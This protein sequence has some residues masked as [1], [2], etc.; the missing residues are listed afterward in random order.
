MN[1]RKSLAFHPV[2]L[3]I[4]GINIVMDCTTRIAMNLDGVFKFF[5]SVNFNIQSVFTVQTY[6]SNTPYDYTSRNFAEFIKALPIWISYTLGIKD[7]QTLTFIWSGGLSLINW[8]LVLTTL[9]LVEK[10]FPPI[11]FYMLSIILTIYAVT[12]TSYLDSTLNFALFAAVSLFVLSRDLENKKSKLV[13]FLII[14]IF[15]TSTHEIFLPILVI[16]N[17]FLV[18]Q[19]LQSLNARQHLLLVY[20]T[21]RVVIS[22]SSLLLLLRHFLSNRDV[23]TTV[24]AALSPYFLNVESYKTHPRSILLM[25]ALTVLLIS[26]LFPARSSLNR[27]TYAILATFLIPLI[28]FLVIFDY[29]NQYSAPRQPFLEFEYRPDY[30]ILILVFFF[31]LLTGAHS[32]RH[33][34]LKFDRVG[35]RQIIH[36]SL[37]TILIGNSTTH[38]IGNLNWN[39][40]WVQNIQAQTNSTLTSNEKMFGSCNTAGWTTLMTSIVYSNSIRPRKFIVELNDLFTE[41][42]DSSYVQKSDDSVV[43]PFGLVFPVVSPGL[44]LTSLPNSR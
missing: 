31:L 4:A 8:L 13:L 10:N 12:L 15:S 30:S 7:F 40:C 33:L 6:L 18:F 43:F 38:I 42:K 35:T 20:R 14:S 21:I 37:V 9:Y 3:A 1:N 39:K 17:C 26:L 23:Y 16:L 19:A 36:L 28:S 27:R 34:G 24:G 5:N 11:Y 32:L 2:L 41:K 22:I 44:D 25:I 29:T